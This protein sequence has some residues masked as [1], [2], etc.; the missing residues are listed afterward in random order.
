MAIYQQ[1]DHNDDGNNPATDNGKC[2]MGSWE[3]K[4]AKKVNQDI[5]NLHHQGAPVRL[6]LERP[7]SPG[8]NEFDHTHSQRKPPQENIAHS[9]RRCGTDNAREA[10][11]NLNDG[12]DEQ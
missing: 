9:T 8:Q 6:G 2:G 1:V 12:L 7:Q 4:E 5:D 10:A 11:N 3:A